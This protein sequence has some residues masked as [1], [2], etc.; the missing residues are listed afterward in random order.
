GDLSEMPRQAPC[1]ALCERRRAGR[2]TAGSNGTGTDGGAK[3]R[4][5]GRANV[6]A[7]AVAHSTNHS[8]GSVPAWPGC[9]RARGAGSP[10]G[11]RLRSVDVVEGNL[12]GEGGR[13]G[14]GNGR[15][16]GSE[17]R[18]PRPPAG[19]RQ[20]RKCCAARRRLSA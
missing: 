11:R 10:G 3:V 20:D 5:D 6:L 9:P 1:R 19:C 13:T 4:S 2:S 12:G 16:G 14:R 8:G 18:N 7:D 17:T 15:G